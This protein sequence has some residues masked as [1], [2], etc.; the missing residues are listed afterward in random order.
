MFKFSD[1]FKDPT[2]EN[3]EALQYILKSCRRELSKL[4]KRRCSEKEYQ[5]AISDIVDIET[6]IAS[7]KIEKSK[8]KNALN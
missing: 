2:D 3:I 6:A 7:M 5:D 4:K 1:E 8:Q